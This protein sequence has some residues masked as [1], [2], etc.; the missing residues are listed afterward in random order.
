MQEL[1]G[2][3]GSDVR[4]TWRY[5]WHAMAVAWMIALAG[6]AMIHR[7]PDRYEA[8]AR[9][10]VD[11]Q[12]VV[13]SLLA[14]LTA[15]PNV[16]EMVG[17]VSRT[18]LS[19]PNLE[20]VV[21]GTGMDAQAK[22]AREH[23]Q[24]I[25]RL[26]RE[27]AVQAAGGENLFTI[28]YTNK[29]PHLAMEVVKSLVGIFEERSVGNQRK[30]SD[31]AR[32]FIDEQIKT[33]KEV[34][35]AKEAELVRFKRQQV[36]AAG[37]RADATRLVDAKSALNEAILDLEVAETNRNVVKKAYEDATEVPSLLGDTAPATD[38][39][40]S[41]AEN[42]ARVRD[43]E[44]KLENLRLTYTDQHPDV[45]ALKRTIAQLKSEANAEAGQKR[46]PSPVS[47]KVLDTTYR[48]LQLSL[49]T[50]EAKL[51]EAKSRVEEYRKRYE[52][53]RAGAIAAPQMDADLANVT[54]DY[55][56]AKGTYA[57]LLA[58]RETA[59]MSREMEVGSKATDFRVID[60]PRV[61]EAPKGP[62][63]PLLNTLALLVAIG[64]GVAFAFLL[65]RVWPT[66]NDERGLREATG[67]PV[68]GTVVTARTDAQRARHLRGL[69]ALLTSFACLL[70]AYGAIMVWITLASHRV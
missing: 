70:T 58:R 44:R 42:D 16:A 36:L 23:E 56:L 52:E 13:K 3:F 62:N 9:V 37:A 26:T 68:F 14:G 60:P 27:V 64:G 10:W 39:G 17:M 48:P 69:T 66:F 1:A 30:D 19:R 41:S 24:L 21:E 5:R 25:T 31:V 49:A 55:E 32:R 20:R 29:D 59:R 2:Q 63:R 15:Q 54:R 67:L 40:A 65:T 12:S 35:D 22:S 7:M 51:A 46:R 11:T 28:T 33:A 61:P 57:A 34:L 18:L 45:V 6:W 8:S 47:G 50:A 53:L 43:L 38:A 4:A